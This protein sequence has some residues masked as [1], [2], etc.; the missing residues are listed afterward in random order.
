[1]ELLR[2]PGV[3]FSKRPKFTPEFSLKLNHQV[4][5]TQKFSIF[6]EMVGFTPEFTIFNQIC[7]FTPGV[8]T[9]HSCRKYKNY[10]ETRG[11]FFK[12]AQIY[13][14]IFSQIFFIKSSLIRNFQ[15]V[16][17][18]SDLLRNLLFLTK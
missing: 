4:E 10:S 13:S 2:N 3:L 18:W 8:G 14:G 17:K 12:K 16:L 5:F 11:Y 1:M 7:G 6:I 9:V 15:L